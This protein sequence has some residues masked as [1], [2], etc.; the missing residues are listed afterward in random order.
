MCRL[1]IFTHFTYVRVDEKAHLRANI[2]PR[3]S[4]ARICEHTHVRRRASLRAKRPDG[5]GSGEKA[6]RVQLLA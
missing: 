3:L 6:L 4:Q 5:E 1:K 2:V